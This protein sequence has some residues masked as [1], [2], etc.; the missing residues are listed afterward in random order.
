MMRAMGSQVAQGRAAIPVIQGSCLG[1]ST[2]INSAI[3]W[4][5]PEDVWQTWQ[6][7]FG[8]G[9]ALPL[10]ALHA[11]WDQ[12][13]REL[14]A[15]PTAPEIWGQNN[16]LLAVAGQRLGVDTAPLRRFEAGCRGSARCMTGCP[17]GA[18]QSMLV[19]YLPYAS[20]HG[21]TL[22]TSARVDRVLWAA[23]RAAGVQG[24]FHVP[25]FK[26]NIAP[27]TLR[28]RK[29]VLI[30]AS[31]IQTPGLLARSGVRSRHLGQHFQGHPGVGLAGVFDAPVAMWAG[32]TQGYESAQ[33][34]GERA[35]QD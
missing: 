15:R 22:F 33:Q 2:V 34:R 18:K 7:E 25:Q 28:A 17:F 31:A 21:A 14:S 4:R 1:G 16:R 5:M 6:T 10:E 35:L 32:A 20:E 19:S 24:Q 11:H 27:F 8:L 13:E 30:A 12:I 29:G 9:A 3:A 26:K 23:G